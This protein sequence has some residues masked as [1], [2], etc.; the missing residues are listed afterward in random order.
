TITSGLGA[1]VVIGGTDSDSITTNRGETASA[2][3]GNAIVIGDN[4]FVDYAVVDGNP[5][6]IDRIFSIDP[7]TGGNDTITT[8]SGADIVIGGNGGDTIG[9]G[10]GDNIVLGDNGLLDYLAV[11]GDPATIDVIT[12]TDPIYGG[13][14][15]ITTGAGYDLIL[16]GTAG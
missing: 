9:A 16:G 4:G 1:D 14:D 3:D 7:A 13:A 2:P 5:A 8:G 6:N 10:D 11:D 12:T 15:S